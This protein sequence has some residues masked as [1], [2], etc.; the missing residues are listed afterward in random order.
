V[1]ARQLI[2][3]TGAPAAGKSMLAEKVALDHAAAVARAAPDDPALQVA[4]MQVLVAEEP[5][6]LF[7]AEALVQAALAAGATREQQLDLLGERTVATLLLG[8]R[9][10][11]LDAALKTLKRDARVFKVL[12]SERGGIEAA[13]NVLVAASNER[14]AEVNAQAAEITLAL[15]NRAGPISDALKE[16]SARAHASGRYAPAGR[17]LAEL[18]VGELERGNLAGL[19][20]G[21]AGRADGLA[22]ASERAGDGPADARPGLDDPALSRFDDPAGAGAADQASALERVVRSG[23]GDP[24]PTPA[25]GRPLD[26]KMAVPDGVTLDPATGEAVVNTRTLGE[27]LDELEADR[28]FVD[29]LDLCL[30]P[31]KGTP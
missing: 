16:L 4:L 30:A 20:D 24:E 10:K 29:Q 27:V 26:R 8:A 19:V 18:V 17:E 14:R 2:I 12:V 9:A 22:A 6:N 23:L 7:Q 21:G 11:V 3:F 31:R 25:L 1:R 5:Q 15:A 13:G 28:E